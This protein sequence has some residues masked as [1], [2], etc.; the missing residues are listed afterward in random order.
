[1]AVVKKKKL[2]LKKKN[3]LIFITCIILIITSIYYGFSLLTTPKST[4]K[5][6]LSTKKVAKVSKTKK[7]LKL[8]INL[9]VYKNKYLIKK[10]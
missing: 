1:M 2:R 9:E 3:F 7:E 6:T 4:K 10:I 8:E 5:E